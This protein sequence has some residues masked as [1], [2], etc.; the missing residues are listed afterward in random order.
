[1]E[2]RD[3]AAIQGSQNKEVRM[4]TKKEKKKER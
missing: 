2:A 1:M 4:K 3:S